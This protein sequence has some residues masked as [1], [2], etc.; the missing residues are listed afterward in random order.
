[1][2]KFY[3]IQQ[4]GR[5][6]DI[7]I[8]GYIMEQAFW[9][10]ETAAADIIQEINALD[11]ERINVHIDCYGGSVSA[12][13]AIYNALREHPAQVVTYGDGFI[14]SAAL[15]PFL[16][17]DERR[18]SSLSA[19]FLHEVMTGADGYAKDLRAA[20]DE[21]EKFTEIGM[22]AFIERAGMTAERVAELMEAETWLSPQEALDEGIATAVISDTLPRMAQSAKRDF[23]Q[24][25]IKAPEQ[26]TPPKVD[27]V[28]KKK[29]GLMQI[30][31]GNFED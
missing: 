6:A 16:A 27:P 10:D 9:A 1:M 14:A 4:A 21:A 20:A 8:F 2:S 11:A 30:M 5:T 26:K 23:I 17:G 15:Y 3:A 22:T 12:G 29:P 25:L 7:Y 19:Y 28:P 18:A 24:R 13:W 31:A